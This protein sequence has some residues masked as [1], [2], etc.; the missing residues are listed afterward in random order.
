MK[1]SLDE[2]VYLDS[3]IHR[4]QS[5]PKLIA[6]LSLIFCFAF[7]QRLSFLPVIIFI[8]V[9]L[10]SLSKLPIKYLISHLRYPGIFI[11]AVIFLLPFVVGKTTIFSWGFLSI[12]QE[13]CLLILLVITRFLCIITT[14]LVL[15][16]TSPFLT[17]LKTLRSLGLS[18]IISDMMLLTYRYLEQM[19]DRILSMRRALK[20]K[21]FNFHQFSSRNLRIISQLIGS[22]LVRSYDESKLV[23]QAMILRGYGY[24]SQGKNRHKQNIKI[25]DWI[26]CYSVVVISVSLI[27]LQTIS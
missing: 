19:G 13:G 23:Y 10:Y 2:Y 18:P 16:G 27:I 1:L 9:I 3:L 5:K 26:A 8:T 15:L 12:K 17:I 24:N 25:S 11:L 6:L 20:L 22:L 4:W 14:T 21:G 7:I